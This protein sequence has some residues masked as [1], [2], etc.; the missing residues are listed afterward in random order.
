MS[1]KHINASLPLLELVSERACV[2]A[3][4]Y[5][6]V[7]GGQGD[8]D[9]MHTAFQ[10]LMAAVWNLDALIEKDMKGEPP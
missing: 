1:E 8:F 6:E 10:A 2:L 9:A 3:D 4:R 7:K 5:R